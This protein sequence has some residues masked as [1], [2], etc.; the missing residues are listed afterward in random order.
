[1]PALTIRLPA[2]RRRGP[3]RSRTG[4][5]P[6]AARPGRVPGHPGPPRGQR[7]ASAPAGPRRRRSRSLRRPGDRRPRG[8]AVTRPGSPGPPTATARPTRRSPDACA[9]PA[10]GGRSS[11]ASAGPRRGRAAPSAWPPWRRCCPRS[12][13]SGPT[14]SLPT[15]QKEQPAMTDDIIT[16]SAGAPRQRP[17]ARRVRGHPHRH[18]RAADD[19]PAVRAERRQGGP[20]PRLDVRPRGRHRGHGLGVHR[21]GPEVQDVRLADGAPRAAPRPRSGQ[22]YPKS[23]LIGREALATIAIDEGGW[24]KIANLSARPKARAA[25][26]VA[27][28]ARPAAAPARPS[29]SRSRS[30]ADDLRAL[31]SRDAR[32]ASRSRPLVR[33]ARDR[34]GFAVVRP[35]GGRE[36]AR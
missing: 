2:R 12:D 29:R 4:R 32:S 33:R 8:R 19:L 10:A 20:A 16:I 36:G 22:S 11:P 14:T 13:G 28:A 3:P 15:P 21:V 7:R 34:Q 9:P 17:H 6:H 23:Q 31:L 30:L 25:A 27:A 18:L 24:A 1:M 5:V 26:P 35:P